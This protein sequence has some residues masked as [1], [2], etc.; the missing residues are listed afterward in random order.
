M[1]TLTSP[2]ITSPTASPTT[3]LAIATH[4]DQLI[5]MWLSGKSP[6]SQKVYSG[7]VKEFLAFVNKAIASVTYDDISRWVGS[8]TNYSTNTQKAKIATIKSLFSFASKLNYLHFNPTILFKEPKATNAIVER[9]LQT[10]DIK[11]MI[12]TEL[13]NRNQLFLKTL[14]SLGLRV[15]EAI[16]LTFS[17]ICFNGSN[18]ILKVL[19]KGQKERVVL[20]PTNLYNEL[21]TLKSDKSDY[22]FQSRQG[23]K[24]ISRQQAFNI[25]KEAGE[26]I[27][28]KVSPHYLRHSHATHA[29]V[30][31]CDLNLLSNNLGHSSL[32][33]TGKY[34][35]IASNKGSSQFIDC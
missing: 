34:L 15:S 8:L 35:H 26:R 14:Y 16:N 18:Y 30:N 4:D 17:D 27:G 31:G 24:N 2:T 6:S 23:N 10:K 7:T 12:K 22:I 29:L 3:Q 33:V 1:L 20:L 9:I 13:N 5:E 32:S 21:L 25:I 11:E 28:V 19:G